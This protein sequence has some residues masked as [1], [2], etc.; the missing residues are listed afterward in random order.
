MRRGALALV[1]DWRPCTDQ[2]LFLIGMMFW[3]K[4]F[5]VGLIVAMTKHMLRGGYLGGTCHRLGSVGE[6]NA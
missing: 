5:K 1:V 4:D 6:S 3:M 2:E